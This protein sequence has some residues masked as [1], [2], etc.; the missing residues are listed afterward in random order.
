MITGMPSLDERIARLAAGQHAASTRRQARALGAT[1]EAVRHREESG[2]WQ[3]VAGD[4]LRIPGAPCTWR[5]QLSVVTLAGGA[6][7]IHPERLDRLIDHVD[8]RFH[9]LPK[10]RAIFP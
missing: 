3:P 4:V 10:L 8:V 2:R 1:I 5:Q 9:A 6:G 7:R